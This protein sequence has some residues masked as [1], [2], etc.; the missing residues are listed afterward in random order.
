MKIKHTLKNETMKLS[1]FNENHVLTLTYTK[2][3]ELLQ[4][5]VLKYNERVLYPRPPAICVVLHFLDP[6]LELTCSHVQALHKTHMPFLVS[7]CTM[8]NSIIKAEIHSKM[9][10]KYPH[11]HTHM[12]Q[13]NYYR[14]KILVSLTSQSHD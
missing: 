3:K 9:L 4:Y 14:W 7:D 13:A 2:L 5:D 6:A 11:L 8:V 1:H 12:Y 10:G